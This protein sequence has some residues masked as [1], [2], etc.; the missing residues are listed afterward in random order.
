METQHAQRK[1][2]LLIVAVSSVGVLTW[3]GVL[4]L[5]WRALEAAGW[6][7]DLW[8]M[9]GA[10]STAVA[11]AAVFTAGYVAYRELSEISNSRLIDITQRL[12]DELNSTENIAARRWVYQNLADD[13]QQGLSVLT[14][15]GQEAIKQVLNS[16]D[17]VAFLTQPGWIDDELIMP[18]MNLMVVKAWARLGPYVLYERQRRGEPDYYLIA[19]K[20]A[21]RCLAW[22]ESHLP[23][24]KIIWVKNAL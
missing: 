24:A 13:P 3:L 9:I 20:L 7:V 5:L 15:E 10:L 6:S 21:E 11:T 22:R 18:W 14:P 17:R 19:Q 23:D 1:T 4:L 8:A 12:F 2:L 16:L